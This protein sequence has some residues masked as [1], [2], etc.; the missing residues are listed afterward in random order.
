MGEA[1][2][3]MKGFNCTEENFEKIKAFILEGTKAEDWWQEYRDCEGRGKRDEFWK[4]FDKKF[5]TIVKYL[6]SINL[7]GKDCNNDLAG[8]LDFGMFDSEEDIYDSVSLD[9]DEFRYHAYVW[10]FADWNGLAKF[11]QSEYGLRSIRWISD[12]YSDP[13]DSLG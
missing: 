11:I 8:Y 5:P 13:F 6:K 4:H 3:Y 10:H 7:H 2:Y 12:E 1:T 9:G